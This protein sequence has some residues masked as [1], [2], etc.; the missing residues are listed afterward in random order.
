MIDIE[1]II[2]KM[3]AA[4]R[5]ATT[6]LNS[7][8][9]ALDAEKADGIT[10]KPIPDEAYFFQTMDERVANYDPCLYYEI[11][12]IANENNAHQNFK[13]Y[14]VTVVIIF[15]PGIEEAAVFSKGTPKRILRYS[16]ALEQFF[17]SN[18]D[19][20]KKGFTFH[21]QSLVPVSIQLVNSSK[22]L[23]AVGVDL[24]IGLAS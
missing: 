19:S 8:F 24:R 6:G 2:G 10:L 16:R 4:M 15:D 18:W 3:E 5:N 9:T 13:A 17:A 22:P 20:I 14:T 11:S 21:V 7:V 12:E 1:H 23:M